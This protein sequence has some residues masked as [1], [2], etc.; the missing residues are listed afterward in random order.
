MYSG[1]SAV[2]CCCPELG[3]F[4]D[5]VTPQADV[6]ILPLWFRASLWSFP[7]CFASCMGLWHQETALTTPALGFGCFHR[8]YLALLRWF[9]LFDVVVAKLLAHDTVSPEQAAILGHILVHV[10]LVSC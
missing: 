5:G 7:R 4:V 2:L 8:L 3:S 9:I 10:G 1:I 6:S